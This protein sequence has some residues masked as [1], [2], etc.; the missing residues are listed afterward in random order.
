MTTESP[1]IGGAA[2]R[3]SEVVG[4]IDETIAVLVARMEAKQPMYHPDAEWN[5]LMQTCEALRAAKRDIVRYIAPNDQ[6]NLPAPAET[7]RGSAFLALL[8]EIKAYIEQTEV[9]IDGEWG[10]C[11]NLD[12]LLRDGEMPELYA[13][14]CN[15]LSA[16]VP[17]KRPAKNL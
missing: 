15:L 16:N 9:T 7:V 12:E 17:D 2:G 3:N 13:K 14:V 4:C 8:P 1:T 5:A 6:A 11:K 10:S